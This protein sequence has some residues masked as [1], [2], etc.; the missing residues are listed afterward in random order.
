MSVS[1]VLIAERRGVLFATISVPA[2]RN[3]LSPDVVAALAAAVQA[4]RSARAL[5]VRGAGGVFSAGGSLGSFQQRLAA[6]DLGD[7]AVATR[8]R[9]FGVFLQ[10]LAALPVPVL[11]AV[12]GAAMGGAVGLVATADIVIATAD[13]RFGLPETS[14]GIVPAQIGPFLLP[15]L[16]LPVARRLALTA[17]RIDAQEALRLGL[18]DRVAPDAAAL[19]AA[20]A[21]ELT[22]LLANGPAALIATKDYLARCA[23]QASGQALDVGAALFAAAMRGEG[24]DGIAARREKR[25]APWAEPF[26]VADLPPAG[27]A[28]A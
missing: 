16:G 1:P 17:Q 15:R 26:A 14:L 4:A 20:L 10:D 6:N 5:V 11:A 25:P 23:V 24:R 18:V 8:N 28:A 9:R 12:H 22:R 19:D 21:E 27:G 2:T 7:D 13:A 3:A